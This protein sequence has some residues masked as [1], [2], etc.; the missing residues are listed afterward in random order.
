MK[1][2]C[3]EGMACRCKAPTEECPHG[4]WVLAATILGSSLAFID[5]TVMT[6]ALPV[7]Q[8]AFRATMA[9]VQWVI[10]SYALLLAALLLLGGSLGDRLGRRRIYLI[11]IAVFAVASIC[12]GLSMNVHQ[13][14]LARAVQGIG[15]ALLVPGSL[16]I[17]SASFS[18]EERGRAIGTW[19]GFTAITTGLGPVLG[20]WLVDRLSWRWAFFI[21]VPIAAAVILLAF[22]RV[23]ES[24]SEEAPP[25]LDWQGALLAT[26]GLGLL[27]F[28]LIESPERGWTNPAVFGACLAGL[29][30]LAVFVMWEAH[31]DSPM[32]PLGLFRLRDFG[33]ASLVTL[34][35][36]T[37]LVGALFFLPFNLIQVQGY[38]PIQAGA[39]LLPFIVI[40]FLLSRW[41][42]GLA[43]RY[44]ARPLLTVGPMIAAC[45]YVLFTLPN[46]G[47]TYWRT[48]FAPACVLGLGMAASVAPLTTTVMSAAGT[49]RAGI[50]SGINNAASRLAGVLAVALFGVI[51]TNA[52]IGRLD[53]NLG[54]ST[55]ISRSAG[56]STRKSRNLP[57]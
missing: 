21:N 43:S 55:S 36:Y 30:L 40:M 56:Q 11:G 37:A 7:V 3:E 33:G 44:G 4:A 10:E 29:V 38:S 15:G 25:K 35:L 19:S 42:G 53:A 2:P 24:R 49:D 57:P 26:V 39:S 32:M 14:I 31:T 54:R 46:V 12:C 50:A 52:F 34:F 18:E 17:I 23:P 22:F 48:F 41:A 45:S 51:L 28:G 1:N 5:A 20:G 6:V 9:Q 8:N 27:V 47:G 13:L 16:A